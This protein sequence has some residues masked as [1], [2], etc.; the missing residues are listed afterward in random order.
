MISIE[1]YFSNYPSQLKVVQLMLKHG[2][3]VNGDS[4]YV[5]LIKLTDAGLAQAAEVDRRVV[6]ST[7]ER[8]SMN[9][10]LRAL[11][12][13]IGSMAVLA[14]AANLLGCSAIEIVPE[15]DT[16]PG[17]LAGIMNIVS[18]DGLNVRQA[19]VSGESDLDVSHLIVVVDGEIPGNVLAA[20]RSVPGVSRVILR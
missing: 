14:D 19:V 6:R 1:D 9:P 8:I 18:A 4:A 3:S 2:I 12:S 20:V 11:F 10:E 7:I 17:L 5:G 16:R 13:R 15:D